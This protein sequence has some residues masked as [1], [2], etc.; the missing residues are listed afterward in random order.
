MVSRTLEV[1]C[2]SSLSATPPAP[3]ALRSVFPRLIQ[4]PTPVLGAQPGTSVP[5]TL[6][7]RQK[8]LPG[9]GPRYYAHGGAS[10]GKGRR[11]RRVRLRPSSRGPG[12]AAGCSVRTKRAALP[13]LR[14]HR[15]RVCAQGGARRWAG[16]RTRPHVSTVHAVLPSDTP[17]SSCIDPRKASLSPLL[18]TLA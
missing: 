11:V 8:R 4:P 17:T 6:S 15:V 1:P 5:I 7:D 14:T 13:W 10:R 18:Q 16:L 3:C 2:S 12:D 9:A